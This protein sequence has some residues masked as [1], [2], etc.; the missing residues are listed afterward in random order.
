MLGRS[1]AS[2]TSKFVFR[3]RL[4]DSF[5]KEFELEAG[6]KIEL[7]RD[8]ARNERVFVRIDGREEFLGVYDESISQ[9]RVDGA[10]L[11]FVAR[12]SKVELT[13]RDHSNNPIIQG[14]SNNIELETDSNLSIYQQ[15]EIILGTDL[16]MTVIPPTKTEF[17]GTPLKTQQQV[18]LSSVL[19]TAI[20]IANPA[21][22]DTQAKNRIM[23]AKDALA[24]VSDVDETKLAEMAANIEKF[25]TA[26]NQTEYER[27][28]RLGDIKSLHQEMITVFS[29]GQSKDNAEG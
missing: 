29:E 22:T 14:E 21:I 24:D 4:E 8:E 27:E 12:E 1:G 13:N 6:S 5:L 18:A 11:E 17:R 16:K 15:N 9:L 3:Q 2:M 19:E 28:E 26:E 10:P 7:Y 20:A 25:E 23:N